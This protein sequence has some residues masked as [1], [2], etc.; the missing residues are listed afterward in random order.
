MQLGQ[1]E[2]PMI[3]DVFP[4]AVSAVWNVHEHSNILMKLRGHDVAD[5]NHDISLRARWF[6]NDDLVRIELHRIGINTEKCA[7]QREIGLWKKLAVVLR[8]E[9]DGANDTALVGLQVIDVTAECSRLTER[10]NRRQ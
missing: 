7:G 2:A 6:G 10:T 3:V 8:P 4:I 1:L 5:R 9:R